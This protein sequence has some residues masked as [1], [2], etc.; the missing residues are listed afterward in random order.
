MDRK[1]LIAFA[2]IAVVLILTPWYMDLVSPIQKTVA[3]RE[4]D[5]D[6][7]QNKPSNSGPAEIKAVVRSSPASSVETQSLVVSNGL[8]TATVS[9]KNGGS[10]SKFLFEKYSK[11]DS[12]NVNI[13]DHYNSNNLLLDF[14]SLDGDKVS[15][16]GNWDVVGS[17]FNVDATSNQK[18]VTFKTVYNN[19]VIK[20]RLT[21]R[22]H[23]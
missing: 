17:Y 11:Y 2:L 4:V 20:K 19:Y 18:S 9:N 12:S 5:S 22:C 13:I 10:F 7:T 3:V 6:K 1:T 23:F 21:F 15:L 14:V 16:G 8:Y